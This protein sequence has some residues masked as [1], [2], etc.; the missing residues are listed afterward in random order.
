MSRSHVIRAL[1]VAA[2]LGVGLLVAYLRP[3]VE[4]PDFAALDESLWLARR[5]D[6]V[7]Q[8][9]LMLVGALGI[10]A[11]LPSDHGAEEG[12]ADGAIE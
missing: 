1:G 7:L 12:T 3:P 11:L 8:L 4:Q 5:T 10:H 2:L 6:L 9:G